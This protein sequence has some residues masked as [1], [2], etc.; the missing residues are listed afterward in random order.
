MKKAR[1]SVARFPKYNLFTKR[2]NVS[3][4][5]LDVYDT[6]DHDIHYK[7]LQAEKIRKC[8]DI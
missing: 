5:K 2:H 6:F 4:L 8:I 7:C 1:S 3:P